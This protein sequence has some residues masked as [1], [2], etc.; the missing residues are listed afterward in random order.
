MAQF[1]ARIV[2][3]SGRVEERRATEDQIQQLFARDERRP[4]LLDYVLG[5]DVETGKVAAWHH[6]GA[7]APFTPA[8]L[9]P[10]RF[11]PGRN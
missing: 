10:C 6:V 8:E 2:F 7:P 4:R 9:N 11:H 1:S 5:V 3:K